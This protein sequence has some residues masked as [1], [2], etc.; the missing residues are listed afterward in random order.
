MR[1]WEYLSVWVQEQIEQNSNPLVFGGANPES[2]ALN[3]ELGSRCVVF[4]SSNGWMDESLTLKFVEWVIGKYSFLRRS[5]AW[6]SFD[7]HTTNSVEKALRDCKVDSQV[8][9]GGCT[10]YVQAPDVS[11]NKSFKAMMKE[12]YDSWLS[13]GNKEYPTSGNFKAPSRKL[14]VEWVLESW[15]SISPEFIKKSFK[16]CELNLAVDRSDDHLIHCFTEGQTCDNGA[17]MLKEQLLVRHELSLYVTPFTDSEV[18]DAIED[19]ML[20]DESDDKDNFID[21][22]LFSL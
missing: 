16:V 1:K 17:Q 21:I 18:E 9:P 6:D 4:L 12:L 2:E 5:L 22:D 15:A 10:K 14:L 19:F 7:S 3:K 13:Q 20:V 8:I 11:R